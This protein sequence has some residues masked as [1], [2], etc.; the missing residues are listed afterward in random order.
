MHKL[1]GLFLFVA[2]QASAQTKIE[3][4]AD[5]P[6]VPAAVANTDVSVFDLSL[7]SRLDEGTPEFP[8]D[9]TIA[10]AQAQ[11]WLASPAGQQHVK[12]LKAAYAGQQKLMAYGIQKIPAI[13]FDGGRFVIY[14]T[15]DLKLAV[16]D[17]DDYRSTHPMQKQ[18]GQDAP[19][20]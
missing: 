7:P 18:G 16:R 6:L 9:P 4:F 15:L 11:A 8:A 20:P 10:Q 14:G 5:G 3:I 13:V 17:Y 2:M 1:L 12:A 19:R